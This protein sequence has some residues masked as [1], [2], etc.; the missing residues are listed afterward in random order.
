[1][2]GYG[3]LIAKASDY[4]L[5]G[6][7]FSWA[8][9]VAMRH[10]ITKYP[11]CKYIWYL[12]QHALIMNPRSKVEEHVMGTQ[13]LEEMMLKD[14]PVVPPDSIIK[15]FSHVRA[16]DIEFVATQDKDGLATS[17]IVVKN[18]EWAKFFLDTWF[19]PMYRSYNFQKAETHA[20][21]CLPLNLLCVHSVP[22][23]TFF[24]GTYRPVAP[25]DPFK[26]GHCSA[27]CC[28]RL[29]NSTTRGAV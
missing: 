28:Q 24:E 22:I 23:L 25:H 10:A 3:T 7:P 4:E 12:D 14:H 1:M 16:R 6:A 2:L 27:T 26:D 19:D 29:F 11:D 15:T 5:G 18:G 21:V 20:L 8:K 9:V 17:S 13:K